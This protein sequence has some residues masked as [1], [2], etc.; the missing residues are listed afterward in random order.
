[1]CEETGQQPF[2]KKKTGYILNYFQILAIENLPK[3]C[4]ILRVL[5]FKITFWLCTEKLFKKDIK[6]KVMLFGARF[7][8]ARI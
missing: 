8:I 2:F 3:N 1:L 5:S 7:S 6:A 4:I